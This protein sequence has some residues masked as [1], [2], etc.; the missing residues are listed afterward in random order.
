MGSHQIEKKI[1]EL[2][3]QRESL[4][5][6]IKYAKLYGGKISLN[7]EIITT[8]DLRKWLYEVNAEIA[9]QI[10]NSKLESVK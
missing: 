10:S 1:E 9:V 7:N 4:Q 3:T 8:E 6:L 2:Y 5:D